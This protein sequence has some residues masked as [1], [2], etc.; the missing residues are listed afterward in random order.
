MTPYL[1]LVLDDLTVDFVSKKVYG[2]IEVF[3]GGFTMNVLAAQTHGDFG[4]MPQG[5]Y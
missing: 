3:I 2:C 4:S 1:V 5:L